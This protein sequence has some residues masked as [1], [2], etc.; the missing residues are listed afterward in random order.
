MQWLKRLVS[1][2]R[3]YDDL[4]VSIQE[5]LDE[6]TEELMDDGLSREEAMQKARRAFGNVTLIQERSREAWQWPRLESILADVRYSLRMM[7]KNPAFTTAAFVTLAIGLTAMTLTFSI[8]NAVL[9][10]PLPA[11]NPKQVVALFASVIP[12]NVYSSCSYPDYEDIRNNMEDVLSDIAAYTIAPANLVIGDQSQHVTL[13]LVSANYFRTLGVD[14][15]RGHLFSDEDES[16]SGSLPE[17]VI[18]EKLWKTKFQ[19][20]SG[21]LGKTVH[22]NKQTYTV[23]GVIGQKQAA[24]RRFFEADVFVPATT[25]GQLGLA[26]VTARTARQYF[27]LGRLRSGVS[28]AQAGAKARWLRIIFKL[29]IRSSGSHYRTTGDDQRSIG[30]QFARTTAG[31]CRSCLGFCLHGGHGRCT[32][33]HRMQQHRQSCA[34]PR[35]EPPKRNRHSSR[36]WIKPVENHSSDAD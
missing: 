34:C 31:V 27:M 12:S 17:A 2:N 26:P 6:R 19:R 22:L 28:L 32:F 11:N 20:N 10:K 18:T 9:F 16:Y 14:A 24:I 35:L 30:T 23:I 33:T 7:R 1:R 36:H 13:G 25:S 4:A 29:R 15:I 5:H 8:A 21:I 3:R